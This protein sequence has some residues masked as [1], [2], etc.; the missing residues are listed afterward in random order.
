M[1]EKLLETFQK[2]VSSFNTVFQKNLNK[3]LPRKCLQRIS[4]NVNFINLLP[5]L[6]NFLHNFLVKNKKEII[7]S[8]EKDSHCQM[9]KAAEKRGEKFS[10]GC[11]LTVT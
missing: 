11:Q 6:K 3:R 8:K 7:E 9:L 5:K 4:H 2:S 1:L 10:F